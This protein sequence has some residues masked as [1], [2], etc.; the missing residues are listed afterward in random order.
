MNKVLVYSKAEFHNV[1][2]ESREGKAYISI[3]GTSEC[4]K[5][6]IKDDDNEHLL[7]SSSDVIN[8]DFDD[9]TEDKFKYKGHIFS[10]ITMNQ[11][12]E[13]VDFVIRNI[14]KDIIVHCKAGR[15]RSQAVGRFII[16][17]FPDEYR[18]DEKRPLYRDGYNP[19]VLKRLKEAYYERF[20]FGILRPITMIKD[21]IMKRVRVDDSEYILS[22]LVK[23]E[24]G[25][26]WIMRDY[27][28]VVH[29][30]SVEVPYVI[31][32]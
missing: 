28:G 10:T 5:Y 4:I 27:S 29:Y 15:S 25:Y 17:C 3:E 16:D 18:E 11:A 32:S 7:P 30:I 23:N 24:E 2:E 21:D 19:E 6:Y 22:G 31:I 26:S 9:V 14:G 12:K 1:V 20:G 8:L 13:V